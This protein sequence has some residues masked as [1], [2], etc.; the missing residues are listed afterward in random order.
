MCARRYVYTDNFDAHNELMWDWD[1]GGMCGDGHNDLLQ[2]EDGKVKFTLK[3]WFGD[4]WCDDGSSCR[5]RRPRDARARAVAVRHT[6]N[7]D[8]THR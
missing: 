6:K 3:D 4:G 8:P 1:A 7:G 2:I 5:G